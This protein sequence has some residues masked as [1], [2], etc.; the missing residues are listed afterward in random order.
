[1]HN[2]WGQ[3]HSLIVQILH[4]T[5]WQLLYHEDYI[6]NNVVRPVL[7]EVLLT[8]EKHLHD[9][10]LLLK[11]EVW[12]HKTNL[13]APLFIEVPVLSQINEKSCI[14]VRCFNFASF[15]Y[16][17]NWILDFLWWFCF[18]FYSLNTNTSSDK[19]TNNEFR[20]YFPSLS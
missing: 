8:C 18:S 15:Y 5:L 14:C 13:T 17:F 11:G 4:I 9:Y 20:E 6:F 10:T 2:C 19:K 16:F 12:S 7:F 1:M 3:R